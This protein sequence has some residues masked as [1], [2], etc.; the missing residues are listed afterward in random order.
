MNL[1]KLAALGFGLTLLIA[2]QSAA[3]AEPAVQLASPIIEL[4][5]VVKAQADTLGLSADQK[6]KLEAWMAEA[7]IKRKAVEQEQI[8]LRT[9]L[10]GTI[11]ALNADD[12]RK[13]LIEQITANEAKLLTMRAKCVDFLRG[14]LTA[15]QFGKVVAAYKAK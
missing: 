6:A 2:A 10:R 3:W 12:E 7:P 5:P 15:E 14:L 9:K 1:R 8:E 4:V 13:S 11:L